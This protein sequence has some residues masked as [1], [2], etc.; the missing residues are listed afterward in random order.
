MAL[1]LAQVLPPLFSSRPV[2]HISFV[3]R[4][5]TPCSSRA[6]MF[7]A[8]FCSLHA[9]PFQRTILPPTPT[10]QASLYD[11]ADTELRWRLLG[12]LASHAQLEP[13]QRPMRARLFGHGATAPPPVSPITHPSA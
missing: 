9:T 13:F 2:I 8:A 12:E 6:V 4:A 7:C 1:P 10:A 5:C 3:A 11:T